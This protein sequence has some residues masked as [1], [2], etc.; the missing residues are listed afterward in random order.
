MSKPPRLKAAAPR[1]DGSQYVDF[2]TCV[3]R[4][5]CDG[6]MSADAERKD[7]DRPST[8]PTLADRLQAAL[9]CEH[10]TLWLYL[11]RT[12]AN[13]HPVSRTG[14]A[15]ALRMS[16]YDVQVAL[17]TF[18]DIEYDN[19]GDIVACGL[20][21][22]PTPHRFKVNGH[23]L[24]TWC[25]LDTLMYPVALHQTAQVESHCPVTSITVRLTV[26]P[27]GVSI[28]TPPE[29]VI[30]IVTPAEQTGCCNIRSSFCSQVHFISSP[31]AAATWLSK[32]P[33][34]TILSVEEA[35]QFGHAIAQRRLEGDRLYSA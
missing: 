25:A 16:S 29:V 5:A 31:Q 34:A 32:N 10:P 3:P 19:E 26:T 9:N 11:L 35:W 30:S 22:L 1:G 27:T 7:V 12:L 8:P 20:S 28:V 24:F 2:L 17:T 6:E 18:T 14:I 13:G 23:D 4:Q 33:E 21:L 15:S